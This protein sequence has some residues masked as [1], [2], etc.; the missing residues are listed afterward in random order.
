MA[1]NVT[2]KAEERKRT[3][4]GVL[5]QMRKEGWI[6]SIVYGGGEENINIKIDA[7][8]F[9]ELLAESASDSFLVNLEI[10]SG[11]KQLAFVQ[12][13]QHNALTGAIM[14]ADFRAVNNKTEIDASIPVNLEGDPVGIQSGGHLE[15]HLYQIE[16]SCFPQDLPETLSASVAHL[17]IGDTLVVGDLVLPLNVK[18]SLGEDVVIALCALTRVAKSEDEEEEAAEGEVEATEQS[19]E[20]AEAA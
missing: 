7:R 10:D 2:L 6:P 17:E 16:I 15:Q 20:S 3:G 5:K 11:K 8:T 14:H 19:E 13:I 12:D 4:T 9:R 1:K 18:C